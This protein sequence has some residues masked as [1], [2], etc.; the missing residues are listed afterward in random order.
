MYKILIKKAR[1][2]FSVETG[3]VSLAGIG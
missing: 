1:F 2:D 3:L